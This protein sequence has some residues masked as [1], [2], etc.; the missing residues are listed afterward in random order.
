MQCPKCQGQSSK[1]IDSRPAE[2]GQSI[3]RRRECLQCGFRFNTHERIEQSPLLVV[4]RDGT[5]E[6][7]NRDKL[8]RGIVRSAEKRPIAVEQMNELVNQVEE[9]IR[10]DADQE[11]ETSRIGEYV[12]PL[13]ME[14][15]EVAYI[16]F[17]SVYREFQSR[18]SFMKELESMAGKHGS[19][20]EEGQDQDE[21]N[22]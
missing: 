12:M 1:V 8:M 2:E 20:I 18:E 19:Q 11:I 17:A 21:P 4:K 6:E 10:D 22:H 3:R 15:D 14:L 5:R 7:F 13:L 16:R 9:S